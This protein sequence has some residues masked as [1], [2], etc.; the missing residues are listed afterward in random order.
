MKAIENRSF[1][2]QLSI[3]SC[4]YNYRIKIFRKIRFSLKHSSPVKF[5]HSTITTKTKT[6]MCITIKVHSSKP[7]FFL[8]NDVGK[9]FAKLIHNTRHLP[10]GEMRGWNQTESNRTRR[11]PASP[12]MTPMNCGKF[13]SSEDAREQRLVVVGV[14]V[15]RKRRVGGGSD[16][17]IFPA[18]TINLLGSRP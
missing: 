8:A 13:P 18:M 12:I 9:I 3:E 2:A 14:V 4:S 15:K 17:M 1:L 11:Q 5:V 10:R 7:V 6:S 16:R